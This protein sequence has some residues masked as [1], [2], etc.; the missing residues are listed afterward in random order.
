VRFPQPYRSAQRGS[1]H[2][3]RNSLY[4]KERVRVRDNNKGASAPWRAR[5]ETLTS[6]ASPNAGEERR[7]S[8]PPSLLGERG[9]GLAAHGKSRWQRSSSRTL[10]GYN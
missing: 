9:T 3:E 4:Q 1:P 2:P 5:R 6:G 10:A 7:L 8:S